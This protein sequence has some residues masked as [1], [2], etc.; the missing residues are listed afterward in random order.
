MTAM[1][2]GHWLRHGLRQSTGAARQPEKTGTTQ[3]YTDAWL[4]GVHTAAHR[5]RV[6]G[7]R[8][9]ADFTREKETAHAPTSIW[10]EF[11]QGA[12]AGTPPMDFPNVVPPSNRPA[13]TTL[14]W[15][16]RIPPPPKTSPRP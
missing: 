10:L 4:R 5:R 7:L 11:M 13:S 14:A 9:Q 2:R 8:R 3:D 16:P 12:V 6:G 15:T 1:L